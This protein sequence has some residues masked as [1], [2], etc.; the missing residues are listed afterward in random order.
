MRLV[1][2]TGCSVQGTETFG[3]NFFRIVTKHSQKKTVATLEFCKDFVPHNTRRI[4]LARAFT[5]LM[6]E[7]QVSWTGYRL[8]DRL[9]EVVLRNG[10]CLFLTLP[11]P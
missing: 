4:V 11:S 5:A 7:K 10:L 2:E 1:G 9:Q 8:P 6:T 3:G